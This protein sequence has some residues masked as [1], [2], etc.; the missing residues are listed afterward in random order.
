MLMMACTPFSLK[1]DKGSVSR[2]ENTQSADLA[3]QISAIDS[4]LENNLQPPSSILV[5][6]IDSLTPQDIPDDSVQAAMNVIRDAVTDGDS[7]VRPAS[8]TTVMQ[9]AAAK[10]KRDTTTMDSLELARQHQP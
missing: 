3:A 10:M 4:A 1:S 9:E 8:P 7:L 5:S 6:Q 2:N